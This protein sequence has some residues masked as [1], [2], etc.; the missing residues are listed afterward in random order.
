MKVVGADDGGVTANVA[1]SDRPALE[2]RNVGDAMLGGEV[3][4]G[5]EPVA[6]ATDD[7]HP[8]AGTGA[9]LCPGARPAAMAAEPLTEQP[10]D[11]IAAGRGACGLQRA[12]ARTRDIHGLPP[13]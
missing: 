10:P 11:R 1:E 4:R 8:V 6:A 5:R 13:S 7:H 3:E 12:R 9:R 2:H